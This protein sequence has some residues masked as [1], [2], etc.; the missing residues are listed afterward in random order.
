MTVAVGRIHRNVRTN[1][2][3]AVIVTTP[4]T[5]EA[6]PS[7]ELTRLAPQ[8]IQN[9]ESLAYVRDQMGHG[10][11]TISVNTY[12]H[13]VPGTN[14]AAVDRLDATPIRLPVASGARKTGSR[15]SVSDYEIGA[16]GWTR[17][18]G[19]ELRR[20]VLYP[21]EL[22][23]RCVYGSAEPRTPNA[24]PDLARRR[25]TRFRPHFRS[26]NRGPLP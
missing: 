25:T 15:N 20:L 6:H 10:S 18:S 16:P 8:L 14:R 4:L 17:T 19:P 13:L 24:P 12:S 21:P 26:L 2:L 23:A 7:P 22:R 9:G 3:A 5:F 11:I 1:P